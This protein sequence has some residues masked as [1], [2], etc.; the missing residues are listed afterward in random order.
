MEDTLYDLVI[1]NIDGSKLADMSHF[2][3]SIVTQSQAK[4]GEH[5]HKKFKVPHQIIS[6]NR[7]LLETD[8]VSDRKLSNI[9][10]QV[11]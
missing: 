10:K 4:K 8:Q 6:G 5:V 11:E 7:K 2:A 9:G 3:A 1:G